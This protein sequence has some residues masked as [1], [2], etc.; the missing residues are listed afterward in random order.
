MKNRIIFQ[1]PDEIRKNNEL[2]R[3]Q[4]MTAL[5]RKSF[6][7]ILN[8]TPLPFNLHF[9]LRHHGKTPCKT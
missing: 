4:G 5:Q 1:R 2:I 7:I 9:L 6:A 3:S 8:S